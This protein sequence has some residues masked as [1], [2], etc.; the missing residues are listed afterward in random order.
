[1]EL[2]NLADRVLRNPNLKLR[3]TTVEQLAAEVGF[4]VNPA[5]G[6]GIT[7]K[8]SD[9]VFSEAQMKYV[10]HSL[11]HF[12]HISNPLLYFSVIFTLF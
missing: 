4:D 11:Y 10:V 6:H 3:A 8:W 12:F 2:G 7:F 9:H 5:Q 1:M